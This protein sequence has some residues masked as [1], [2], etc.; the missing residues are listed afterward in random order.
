MLPITADLAIP[1]DELRFRYARSGGPGG[2]HVNKTETQVELLHYLHEVL[3]PIVA[4]L[5]QGE[6]LTRS[7]ALSLQEYESLLRQSG[8]A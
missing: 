3:P 4:K 8:Q 2:Q 5:Q 6:S 1:W 7:E